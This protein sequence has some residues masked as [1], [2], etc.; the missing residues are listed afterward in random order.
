MRKPK[1]SPKRRAWRSDRK[2]ER[3]QGAVGTLRSARGTSTRKRVARLK[4][5]NRLRRVWRRAILKIPTGL[6]RVVI[7][8]ALALLV[9]A[10]LL[11]LPARVRGRS[12]AY[13]DYFDIE[14]PALEEAALPVAEV[15]ASPTPLPTIT[16]EPFDTVLRKVLSATVVLDASARSRKRMLALHRG[17]ARCRTT[18]A[19]RRFVADDRGYVCRRSA[20]DP[21][22]QCCGRSEGGNASASGI[23]RYDC[24]SCNERGCCSEYEQCV[25]CCLDPRRDGS[26]AKMVSIT[27]AGG[28][29]LIAKRNA[30]AFVVCKERCRYRSDHLTKV[31]EDFRS[32]FRHCFDVGKFMPLPRSV[33]EVGGPGEPCT[34]VCDRQRLV[35]EKKYFK[36]INTCEALHK[37]FD[38]RGGC[39]EQ[40]GAD[41]PAMVSGSALSKWHPGA[42]LVSKWDQIPPAEQKKLAKKGK[43]KKKPYG[44]SSCKAKF[45]VKKGQS[46]TERLCPCRMTEDNSQWMMGTPPF[47]APSQKAVDNARKMALYQRKHA[48]RHGGGG[49]SEKSARI[50]NSL[51]KRLARRQR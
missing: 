15:A 43:K 3:P 33:P 47:E 4:L 46:A 8:G 20:V 14:Q 42:C 34:A 17:K 5:V 1:A 18:K 48:V 30:S 11:L 37:R 38:C 41:L 40:V 16:L 28:G 27:A 39:L 25:A 50:V 29:S 9:L 22:T 44:P 21:A 49:A 12:G 45:M 7:L 23:P 19:G 26:R 36:S 2:A 24:A 6:V 13:V 10:A 32:D 35:C 51:V 31:P